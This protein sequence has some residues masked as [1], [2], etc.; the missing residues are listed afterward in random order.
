[1]QGFIVVVLACFVLCAAGSVL[2][3]LR[4]RRIAR[5]RDGETIEDYRAY[6]NKGEAPPDVLLAVWGFFQR[7]TSMDNFP[8]RPTDEIRDVYTGPQFSDH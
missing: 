4:T 7:W 6:F 2:L 8:V 5:H 3:H 1:M